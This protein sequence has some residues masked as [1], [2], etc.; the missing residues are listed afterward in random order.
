MNIMKNHMRLALLLLVISILLFSFV[1]C[2]TKKNSPAVSPDV[3]S[4]LSSDVVS[5][6][7]SSDSSS[8]SDIASSSKSNSTSVPNPVSS[9]APKAVVT[10][11]ES[12]ASD[13][14]ADQIKKENDRY[15]QAIKNINDSMDKLKQDEI[16]KDGN[17]TDSGTIEHYKMQL[18]SIEQWRQQQTTNQNKIHQ[19]NLNKIENPS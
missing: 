15:D 11:T 17:A 19:D 14:K 3:S 18:A 9:T 4:D 8:S 7:V 16:S 13:A 5:S 2:Q 6:E 10:N 1:G 12:T